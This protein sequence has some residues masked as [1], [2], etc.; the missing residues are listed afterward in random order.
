MQK[1]FVNDLEKVGVPRVEQG[2]GQLVF[3][4]HAIIGHRLSQFID[5]GIHHIPGNIDLFGLYDEFPFLSACQI[6]VVA[7]H[8]HLP[9]DAF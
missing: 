1:V 9:I 3:Y 2:F 8:S 4:C 7:C 5:D 6:K